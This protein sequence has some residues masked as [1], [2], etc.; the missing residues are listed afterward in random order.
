MKGRFEEHYLVNGLVKAASQISSLNE[1]SPATHQGLL[2][3]LLCSY[4]V[5]DRSIQGHIYLFII[6]FKAYV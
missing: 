2:Q 3:E 5:I 4:K 6:I 1:K